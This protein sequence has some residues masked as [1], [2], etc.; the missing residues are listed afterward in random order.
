MRRFHGT[1]AAVILAVTAGCAARSSPPPQARRSVAVEDAHVCIGACDH[2]FV[3]G[4]WYIETG[5]RHGPN[6]GHHLVNG[7]WKKD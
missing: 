6:C 2:F 5:H 7:R 3:D 4:G 1:L